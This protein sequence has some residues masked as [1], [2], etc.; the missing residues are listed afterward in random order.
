MRQPVF[1]LLIAI[2][3]IIHTSCRQKEE[4]VQ[5]VIF[6]DIHN[7]LIPDG[8]KRLQKI[9]NAA[10]SANVDF[11]LEIGDFC[12]PE[13]KN[14]SFMRIWE[15]CP[16]SKYHALG[17][18]D[19]DRCTK[20]EYMQSKGM[21]GRFY[22]FDQ[23]DFHFI[24]LDANHRFENGQYI[25]YHQGGYSRPTSDY[26]DEEQIEW[27]RKD[28]D[29][30]DKRCFIFSHQSLEA[31]VKN[32]DIIQRIFEDENKRSGYK[33]VVAA[34]SGHDH[35]NYHKE[36][37]GITYIQ[38]NSASYI[39]VG[40]KY[41]SDKHYT[42]EIN[43]EYPYLKYMIPYEEAL[44]GI[45]TLDQKGLH[46]KGSETEFVPPTPQELGMPETLNSYPIVPWIK[47]LSV[48][49]SDK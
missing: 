9:I 23:G 27:L 40:E 35:T 24:V 42:K 13:T 15:K 43:E 16:K 31:V 19:M 33:K 48:S 46:L 30:T 8:E 21:E 20:E 41:E 39:W 26:I 49:F 34:F 5:F 32:R 47:D 12:H 38:I 4:V 45:V 1:L 17:N 6:S 29:M 3:L 14:D 36:I 10:D 44:Y 18:H 28:L 7:D 25:P 11:I 22:S 2:F 37:N